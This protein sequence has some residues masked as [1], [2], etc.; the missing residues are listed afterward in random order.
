[1]LFDIDGT[2]TEFNKEDQK[3]V[4]DLCVRN[5]YSIGIDTAGGFSYQPTTCE[6]SI[7]RPMGD[8]LCNYM[9]EHDYDTFNN[10][11]IGLVNGKIYNP[12]PYSEV[13]S[14]C[15]DNPNANKDGCR[16]GMALQNTMIE[17]GA[18]YGVLVDN[19]PKVVE[20]CREYIRQTKINAIVIW[21]GTVIQY[22]KT[23]QL[24]YEM[25]SNYFKNHN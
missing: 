8:Y 4:V 10:V 19:D 23:P 15:K 21:A 6:S 18:K 2:W 3:K 11:N 25:I 24:T 14:M 20:G 13:D 17:V 16:K 1:M 7:R 9:S 22:P 5:N 12:N